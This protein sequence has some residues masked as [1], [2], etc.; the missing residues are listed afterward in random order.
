MIQQFDVLIPEDLLKILDNYSGESLRDFLGVYNYTKDFEEWLTTILHKDVKVI[1]NWINYTKYTGVDNSF[2]WHDDIHRK[3]NTLCIL[4]L[5]GSIGYGGD[6][7]IMND[8]NEIDRVAFKPNTLIV[9]DNR[10]PHK[11]EYYYG[12]EPRVALNF[13]IK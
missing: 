5:D 13:T 8:N 12:T 7:L 10:Y 6:L 11:V 3:G 9:M 4:W 1:K 2:N